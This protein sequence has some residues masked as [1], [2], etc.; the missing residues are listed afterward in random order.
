MIEN[1]AGSRRA[2]GGPERGEVVTA[3]RDLAKRVGV[4]R[5]TMRALSAQLGAAVPSVYRHVP[6]KQAALELVA[7]SVL[8]EIPTSEDGPWDTRLVELY[9]TARESILGVPGVANILQSRPE[10]EPAR[11]LDRYSRDLIA[12]AGL[13]K[14]GAAAAHM[15]L[16]TY[17]LGSVALEESRP[18]EEAPQ[19]RRP[20]AAE[21]RAGLGLIIAGI[22]SSAQGNN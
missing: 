3:L 15:V 9:S 13:T 8:E 19:A 5:V 7:E 17:L 22:K 18:A 11:R 14:S 6:C 16:C 21:F 4:Q 2:Y 20:T 12:Q 1:Q 10:S